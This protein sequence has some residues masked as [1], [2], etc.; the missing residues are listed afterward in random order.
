MIFESLPSTLYNT[1]YRLSG[2]GLIKKT[3]IFRSPRD[4]N[5][6]ILAANKKKVIVMMK[7][8]QANKK[9]V[10]PYVLTSTAD[11][12]SAACRQKCMKNSTC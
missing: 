9:H 8:L 3:S 5:G 12:T 7:V 6:R 2:G 1:L 10:L 11:E 4:S